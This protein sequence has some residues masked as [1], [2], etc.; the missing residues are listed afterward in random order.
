MWAEYAQNSLCKPATGLTQFQCVLGFQPSL[1]NWSGESTELFAIDDWLQIS[2]STW[3]LAHHHLQCA[4]RGFKEQVYHTCHSFP[5]Y[6]AGQWVWLSTLNLWLRL[7]CKKLNLRY[8]GQFKI[9][10]EITPV[11]YCILLPNHYPDLVCLPLLIYAAYPEHH[12]FHPLCISAACP[13]LCLLSDFEWVFSLV[14]VYCYNTICLPVFSLIKTL[15]IDHPLSDPS[16]Q[17]PPTKLSD[18]RIF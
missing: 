10:K 15:H 5:M 17:F 7:P 9:I 1:F 14:I 13:W 3:N 4:V 8:I 18:F 11:S 6:A 2:E 12:L 16:L